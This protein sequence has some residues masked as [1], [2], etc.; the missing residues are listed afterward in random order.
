MRQA[1]KA[2]GRIADGMPPIPG[3]FVSSDKSFA[4]ESSRI[5]AP[6]WK[7]LNSCFL[8]AAR[9]RNGS[10]RRCKFS[11]YQTINMPSRRG[12]RWYLK[13]N[14]TVVDIPKSQADTP[15][16]VTHL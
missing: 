6:L 15:I 14:G 7:Y 13:C 11:A 12:L 9:L 16:T 5:G 3:T 10:A 4:K 2:R 8:R 1:A